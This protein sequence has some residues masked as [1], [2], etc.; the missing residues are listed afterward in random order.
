MDV[1]KEAALDELQKV[2]ELKGW[3]LIQEDLAAGVRA[4]QESAMSVT[5][6]RELGF[7]QGKATAFA[8]LMT[9]D[10]M[11]AQTRAQAHDD[12]ADL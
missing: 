12:D 6:M 10:A 4:C 1:R 8:E 11:I 2:F 9:L 7:L 3:E 5:D